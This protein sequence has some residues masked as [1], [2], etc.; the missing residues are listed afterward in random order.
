MPPSI[1]RHSSLVIFPLAIGITQAVRPLIIPAGSQPRQ[2]TTHVLP[3]GVFLMA[4]AMVCGT[5]LALI[6]SHTIHLTSACSSAPASVLLPPGIPL[7]VF[8]ST[9]MGPCTVSASAATIGRLL[10]MVTM[11]ISSSST[12]MATSF[13]RST[14]LVRAVGRS[15]A[16]KNSV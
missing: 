9:V 5:M 10:L 13:L 2:Y 14:A 16:S 15:V 12:A 1:L 3:V 11:R 4:E 7:R 6:I 8:V